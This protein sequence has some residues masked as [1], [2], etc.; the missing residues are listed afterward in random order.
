MTTKLKVTY[1]APV[2]VL[3]TPMEQFLAVVPHKKSGLR[4]MAGWA[5]LVTWSESAH[6]YSTRDYTGSFKLTIEEL[7][8]CV[9][10][11]EERN[12]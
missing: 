3:H 2:P 7:S 8:A 1:Q 6:Q 12:Q 5:E 4:V 9:K 11:Y 10:A